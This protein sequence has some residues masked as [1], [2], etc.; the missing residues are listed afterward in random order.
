MIDRARYVMIFGLVV[1][2]CGTPTR[3]APV[4]E[5]VAPVTPDVPAGPTT[6]PGFI[7]EFATVGPLSAAWVADPGTAGAIEE[8]DGERVLRATGDEGQRLTL[9]LPE[10]ARYRGRRVALSVRARFAAPQWWAGM[11][12]GLDVARGAALPD[13]GDRGRTSRISGAAWRT[14]TALVDVAADAEA[15]TLFLASYGQ[16]T[17]EVDRVAVTDVGPAGSGDEPPRPLAGPALDNVI[18]FARLYGAVRYFHPSDEASALSEDDWARFVRDGVVAV[19][20]APDR[21]TLATRLHALFAPLAPTARIGDAPPVAV[22]APADARPLAWKRAGLEVTANTPYRGARTDPS[23]GVVTIAT[24]IDPTSLRGV[25]IQLRARILGTVASG[26]DVGLWAISSGADPAQQFYTEPERQPAIGAGWT[27]VIV[28]GTIPTDA[29]Q[30]VVGVQLIG[31]GAVLIDGLTVL[32]LDGPRPRAVTVPAWG[33]TLGAPWQI[34]SDAREGV[35]ATPRGGACGRR[36]GCLALALRPGGT[37]RS[38]WIAELRGVR[39][40]VPL[41]VLRAGDHTLPAATTTWT[42]GPRPL[43]AT[44]RG[45]RLADVIIAWNVLQHFYP[46]FDVVGTDWMAT[47]GPA[48]ADAAIAPGYAAQHANLRRL[49]SLARDGHGFL[50][51]PSEPGG[52]MMPWSW[53]W[54]EGALVIARVAPQCAG[55]D[56]APGDVVTSIDGVATDAAIAARMAERTMATVHHTRLLAIDSLRD[57]PVRQ[58]RRITVRRGAAEHEVAITLV[59]AGT[60][61]GLDEVRPANGSEVAPGIR[62]VDAGNYPP[63]QWQAIAEEL[64]KADVVLIDMRGYPAAWNALPL[65]HLSATPLSSP[66]WHVPDVPR[67]D[68]VGMTSRESHWDV[69]PA[70]PRFRR[71]VFLTDERAV[72]AAETFMG[73]V[74]GHRLGEIV[75]GPTAGTNGNINPVTLPSGYSMMWTGMKV[76]AHDG[77]RHHGVGIQPTVPSAPTIAGIAAG[78]DEVLERAIEIAKQ[79]PRRR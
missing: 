79:P 9:T 46:Y 71:A 40:E 54:A 56:L 7:E 70:T 58:P 44:D 77:S 25:R 37:D 64:A 6:A 20:D 34:D 78:R 41:T 27:D 57:G 19:E 5:P 4:S 12:V 32:R 60:V 14:E 65:G 55:C 73:I 2:S 35:T 21:A 23:S 45:T 63:A 18:A 69:P 50:S 67:P 29:A 3:S 51:H 16:G 48:L 49:L 36:R 76:L 22:D 15:L 13:Y 30:F 26:G 72:S 31:S 62:Y 68:R 74:A 28:D 59:G 8:V 47:L 39:V 43:V 75:G 10:P 53:Q 11:Q 24:A 33:R 61:T 52:G 17:L 38:P 42:A 1:A 66:Q